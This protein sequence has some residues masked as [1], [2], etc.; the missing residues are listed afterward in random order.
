MALGAVEPAQGERGKRR[1]GDERDDQSERVGRQ[2]E[3][4]H[5]STTRGRGQG[6]GPRPASVRR[7][8]PP[9]IATAFLRCYGSETVVPLFS[10]M[11]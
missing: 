9:I 1:N 6:Q 4:A 11:S 5:G 2:I 10:K 8:G 7:T 3:R